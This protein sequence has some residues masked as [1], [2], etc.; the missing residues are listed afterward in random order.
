MAAAAFEAGPKGESLPELLFDAASAC[1]LSVMAPTSER[2][3]PA[4]V[5]SRAISGVTE[6]LTPRFSTNCSTR[7]GAMPP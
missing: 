1:D 2:L 3:P 6:K 5:I 4:A 7:A